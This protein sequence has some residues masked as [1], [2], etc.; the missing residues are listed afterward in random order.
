MRILDSPGFGDTRGPQHDELH[1]K[2]IATHIQE[3]IASVDAV[4]I[5]TNGTFPG[6]TV[7][8]EYALSAFLP[9]TLADNVAFLFTN[10]PSS[11]S[12]N[13]YE[14]G[15][16][17][18]EILKYAPH[19]FLDN[20]IALRRKILKIKDHRRKV[21]KAMETMVKEAEQEALK[22]LVNLFDW[23]DRLEPRPTTEIVALYETSQALETKI[24]N[25]LAQMDQAEAMITEVNKLVKAGQTNSVSPL[26]YSH[27]AFLCMA[28]VGARGSGDN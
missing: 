25:A 4:L 19:F 15:I 18:S 1:K 3:H 7:G 26:P 20:P 12:S 9:K 8:T 23:L 13:V 28:N 24:T 6:I 17:P 5:P 14:G 27:L 10:V 11:L 22:M 16:P 21:K 2:S